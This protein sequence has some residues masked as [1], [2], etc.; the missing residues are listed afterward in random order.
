MLLGDG[1]SAPAAWLQ[2]PRL[3]RRAADSHA[4][5]RLHFLHEGPAL[6]EGCVMGRNRRI[7]HFCSLSSSAPATQLC[8][9]SSL[10]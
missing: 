6:R 2:A 4:V 8:Q 3:S 1:I 10:R 9:S 7:G 5:V